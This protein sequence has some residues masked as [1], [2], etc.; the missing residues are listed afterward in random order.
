MLRFHLME[1]VYLLLRIWQLR[2]LLLLQA[3]SLHAI[4]S[5][6]TLTGTSGYK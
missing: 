5:D 1:A 2:P 6:A 3:V 4:Y